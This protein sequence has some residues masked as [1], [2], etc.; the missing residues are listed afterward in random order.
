M[1]ENQSKNADQPM[2]VP[3]RESV[4]DAVILDLVTRREIGRERYGRELET[5]N[6]RDAERDLYGKLLDALLSAK[7]IRM[8]RADMPGGS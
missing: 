2:P 3:G 8:E 5:H 6:G 7:Q 1:S 4:T